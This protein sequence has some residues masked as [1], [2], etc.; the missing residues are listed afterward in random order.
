MTLYELTGEELLT[1]SYVLAVELSKG[2][3]AN[4]QNVLAAF[5]NAVSDNIAVIAVAN[6]SFNDR[7]SNN[8]SNTSTN[9][10]NRAEK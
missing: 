6:T 8:V 3:T 1:L 2:L 4:E 10:I 7:R 9:N 5:L